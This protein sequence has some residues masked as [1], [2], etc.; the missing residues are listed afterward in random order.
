[1]FENITLEDAQSNL[2]ELIDC[3]KPGAEIAITRNNQPKDYL[4]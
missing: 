1:M 3:L 2:S 4:L